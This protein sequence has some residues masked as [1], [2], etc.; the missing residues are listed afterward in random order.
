MDIIT[1]T[2]I[3]LA[4]ERNPALVLV[5]RERFDEFYEA[6]RREAESHEPDLTTD[7]GRKA[8]GSLAFKIARTKTAIDDA[9]KKLN[10]Q[11]RQQI[12]AVDA[13]RRDIRDRL[14][15]LKD[16][17]RAPLTAWEAQEDARKEEIA[18]R[19]AFLDQI[20][21]VHRDTTGAQIAAVI[22]TVSAM[23]FDPNVYQDRL[24]EI[25][26]R[27]GEILKHLRETEGRIQK[28]E[29]DR[30]E[31][32][33]LRAE[34]E[35]R[36]E[37]ERIAAEAKAA[38]Q[39]EEARKIA[40]IEAAE[41]A[42]QEQKAAMARAAQEAEKRAK[43]DAERAAQAERDKRDAEHQAELARVQKIA[44]EAARRE[45]ARE[46]EAAKIAADEKRRAENVKHR[47]AIMTAAKK[48]LMEH[49]ALDENQAKRVV[50]AI[51]G[52]HVPHVEMRF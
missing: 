9:G 7:R 29:A 23:T 1:P 37:A 21:V 28:E 39:R 40:E 16:R 14:D 10:E 24:A 25:E 8:I 51:T 49:A 17:V 32:D 12:N 20:S 30:A 5:N 41:R 36:A 38:A 26:Y 11:A 48:A 46:A 35:E 22:E 52:N 18:A 50:L 33:R 42:A 47:S 6:I 43:A 27:H 31:L 44:D 3:V 45:K 2:G 4:V 15:A 19:V 34:A 13:A